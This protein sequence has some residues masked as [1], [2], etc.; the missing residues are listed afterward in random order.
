MIVVN[1][2]AGSANSKNYTIHVSGTLIDS[3]LPLTF[4]DLGEK[5]LKLA[6]L[7]WVVQEKLGLYL[8][9]NEG[10]QFLPIESRN[11]VRF[12]TSIRPPEKWDGRIWLSSFGF[13]RPK[14]VFFLTMDFDK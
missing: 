2:V 11:A 3:D 8:G 13:S 4:I 6:S 14:K 9:W 12:D 10:T 5:Q 7:V 1:R